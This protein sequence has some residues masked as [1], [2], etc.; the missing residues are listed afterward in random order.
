MSA[1]PPA[2]PSKDEIAQMPAFE[3]LP[4]ARIHLVDSDAQADFALRTL[5]A[6]R[7]VGFDTE[8]KPTFRAGDVSGGP[9][10]I[11][12]ATL[13]EAFIVQIGPK[14]ALDFLKTVLESKA[15]V[16]VGFGLKSDRGLLEKKLGLHIGETVDLSH[17][18]REQGY[19]Q[20]VGVKAAVAIVLGRRL[21]K[22]RSI[23]TSNW[24]LPKLSAKQIRYAAD[25]AY[26]SLA[27]YHA[28]GIS[29]GRG[30]HNNQGEC[31]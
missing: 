7:S 31:K 22:S 26:A 24:S 23:T 12:L 9:H 6:V 14:T 27:V 28:L 10:V 29:T 30:R 15:I 11:Q 18:L 25:D 2:R 3:G 16:K 17:A 4:P 19:R 8:S 13:E 20:A 21:Q 5:T 1:T